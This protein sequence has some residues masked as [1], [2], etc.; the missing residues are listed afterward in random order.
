MKV[1]TFVALSG[2]IAMLFGL[3]F[4]LVPEF[5]LP[6]YGMRTEPHN[7][8][9]ARFFGGTLLALGLVMWLGRGVRDDATLRALLSGNAVSGVIGTALSLWAAFAGLQ[10]A[11][12]WLSV[13]TYGA[14]LVGALYFLSSPARRS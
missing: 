6:Q 10:N 3:E 4:L 1:S 13:L 11:M 5:G 7:L 2:A 14:L 8:L 9:Q 12:A